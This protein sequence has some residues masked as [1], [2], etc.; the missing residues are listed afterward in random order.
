MKS[1]KRWYVA[2]IVLVAAAIL[3]ANQ[4]PYVLGFI[5]ETVVL[6][7]CLLLGLTC[8][9]MASIYPVLTIGREEK[10]K[11]RSIQREIA[12]AIRAHVSASNEMAMLTSDELTRRLIALRHLDGKLHDILC[13]EF[14][15]DETVDRSVVLAKRY[16]F[17]L[18]AGYGVLRQ[19]GTWQTDEDPVIPGP[20]TPED[21]RL[22]P[23][24]YVASEDEVRELLQAI[25]TWRVVT[26]PEE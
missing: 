26:K 24:A 6:G 9:M 10:R 7:S 23:D 8:Y 15:E 1:D 25:R 20:P 19:F 3:R 18:G 5:P 11:W 12:L 13:M 17:S 16:V 4:V 2:T 22:M 21:F 14:M